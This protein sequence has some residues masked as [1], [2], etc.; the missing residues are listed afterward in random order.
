MSGA[1]RRTKYRKHVETDVLEG[2]PEPG[3]G[4]QIV[5]VVGSRGGNMLEVRSPAN[6]NAL[7][8]LPSKFRKLVWV[9]RGNYMIAT[10]SGENYETAKK[11]GARQSQV[12]C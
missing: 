2:L 3:E 4:E 7:C 11:G 8:L 6:E 1:K 12:H 5:Q 9:K 10:Y